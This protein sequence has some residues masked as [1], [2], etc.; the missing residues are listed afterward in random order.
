MALKDKLFTRMF[1]E[2]GTEQSQE[3][4]KPM[5]PEKVLPILQIGIAALVAAICIAPIAINVI[6]QGGL[7]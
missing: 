6:N 7:K 2:E 5:Q 1:S 4:A 3:K